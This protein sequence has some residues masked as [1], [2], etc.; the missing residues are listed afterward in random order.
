MTR[1]SAMPLLLLAGGLLIGGL[2][3]GCPT[4]PPGPAPGPGAGSC[5]VPGQD[6]VLGG[7]LPT[8]LGDCPWGRD[9][10][11]QDYLALPE[12]FPEDRVEVSDEE[13]DALLRGWRDAPGPQLAPD[14]AGD[15]RQRI[16][17]GTRLDV[18]L[19]GLAERPLDVAIKREGTDMTEWEGS[20]DDMDPPD[21]HYRELVVTDPLVGLMQ[22]VVFLPEGEGPFP[23]VV[24]SHGHSDSPF[25]HIPRADFGEMYL[26]AGYALIL[27]GYRVSGGDDLEAYATREL[28][29][30][31]F[32]LL[33]IRMYEQL[34]AR[35]IVAW[36]PEIDPCAPVGLVG[37]SGG[38][39]SGNLTVTAPTEG[40]AFD[41]YVSDLASV[42]FSWSETPGDRYLGDETVPALWQYSSA[43]NTF[44]A[45]D[46]PLL[47]VPY[48][49]P[50]GVQDQLDF[51]DDTIR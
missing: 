37:H 14:G 36:L 40:L 22:V 20:W 10:G 50:D 18:L 43:I 38:S 32:T 47:H 48:G 2:L 41:A 30:Q 39:V 42:Y 12:L 24:V 27:P 5:A 11:L 25:G 33:G 15:L 51:F 8:F 6:A 17:E 3:A 46:I 21:M 29:K 34:I 1:C 4:A 16:L 35:R 13:L 26:N 9:C 7:P 45:V 44:D 31:G 23:P 19:E 28:L 49:Y